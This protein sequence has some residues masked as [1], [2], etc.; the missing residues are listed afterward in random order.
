M[1]TRIKEKVVGFNVPA[2][3]ECVVSVVNLS[4]SIF[5]KFVRKSVPLL[6][7]RAAES[8]GRTNARRDFIKLD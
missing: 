6:T 3:Q 7:G 2:T 8:Y 1:A 5:R 4:N